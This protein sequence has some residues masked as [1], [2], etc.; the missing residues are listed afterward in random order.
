MSSWMSS[1]NTSTQGGG[2]ILQSS[3][4]KAAIVNQGKQVNPV[5]GPSRSSFISTLI[6]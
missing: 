3:M 2:E 1:N 4:W 6:E 5:S